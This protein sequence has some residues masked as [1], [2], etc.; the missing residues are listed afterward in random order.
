MNPIPNQRQYPRRASFI[1]AE[2][3]VKGKTFRDVIKNIGAGGLFIRTWRKVAAGQSITLQFPLLN[4][5]NTLQVS[6]IVSRIDPMGFAVTFNESIDGLICKEG[7][8]P[9]IVHESDR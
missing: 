6:G 3:T 8:F 7:Q 9:E 2:Y 4:F 1:I 5:E